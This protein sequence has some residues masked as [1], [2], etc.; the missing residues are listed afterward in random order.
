MN[1]DNDSV[2]IFGKEYQLTKFR[3]FMIAF[4]FWAEKLFRQFQDIR[5]WQDKY[6]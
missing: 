4:L 1:I 6:Y 5:I 3:A 2:R